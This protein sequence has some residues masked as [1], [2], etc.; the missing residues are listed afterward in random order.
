MINQK[1]FYKK[2]LWF[3]TADYKVD[4]SMQSALHEL[5]IN[6]VAPTYTFPIEENKIPEEKG[7]NKTLIYILCL[8]I[9]LII[10]LIALLIYTYINIIKMDPNKDVNKK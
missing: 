1:T 4:T 7:I 2:P 9:L 8:V 3:A 5:G 10:F 6:I